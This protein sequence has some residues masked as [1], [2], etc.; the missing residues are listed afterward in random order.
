MG[1]WFGLQSALLVGVTP[2]DEAIEFVTVGAV[3]AKGF[4]V[5]KALDAAGSANLIRVLL[6]ADGPGHFGVPAS[7]KEE[8]A[9]AGEAGGD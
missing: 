2:C 8:H 6:G 4:F 3:S 9:G 7:A 1:L 5:E